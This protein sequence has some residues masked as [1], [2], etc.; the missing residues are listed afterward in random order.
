MLSQHPL[1]RVG[2]KPILGK[3]SS[4]QV[5][6]GRIVM[7]LFESPYITSDANGFAL[8]VGTGLRTDIKNEELAKRIAVA[9]PIRAEE[10]LRVE[11][12]TITGPLAAWEGKPIVGGTN[13]D[14]TFAG[15]LIVELYG[16][17]HITSDVNGLVLNVSPGLGSN[18]TH[19]ALL[20]RI[21]AAFPARAEKVA[22]TEER[23]RKIA[24][25]RGGIY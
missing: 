10:E 8:I 7:E 4:D 2:G 24:Q 13:A 9:L 23:K 11:E 12:I 21:A 6:L 18:T 16:G 3:E 15:R 22:I 20:K 19:E 14:R 5:F 1:A 17:P 25:E